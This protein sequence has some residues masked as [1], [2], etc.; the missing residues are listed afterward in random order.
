MSDCKLLKS[1]LQTCIENLKKYYKENNINN[2]NIKII[3]PE[4]KNGYFCLYIDMDDTLYGFRDNP[5]CPFS[6][7]IIDQTII[8]N[9]M[10][11]TPNFFYDLPLSNVAKKIIDNLLLLYP[12]IKICFVTR[13]ISDHPLSYMEK[14]A[15]IKRD[16]KPLINNLILMQDKKQLYGDMFHLLIDDNIEHISTN[17]P[18]LYFPVS[19]TTP[20]IDGINLLWSSIE[21]DLIFYIDLALKIK[22]LL[23]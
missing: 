12:N 10:R 11:T 8:A 19:E 14:A 5:Q 18:A 20:E 2:L 13:P 3:K 17:C 15:V 21:V 9:A 7:P 4:Y 1:R 23:H 6:Y 16:F 22:Y